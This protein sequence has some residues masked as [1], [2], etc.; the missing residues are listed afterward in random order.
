MLAPPP[1]QPAAAVVEE[2]AASRGGVSRQR[3]GLAPE[4]RA[5]A[6]VEACLRRRPRPR[7]QPRPFE[8]RL[9]IGHPAGDVTA[10]P[11]PRL[12]GASVPQRQEA[13]EVQVQVGGASTRRGRV[14]TALGAGKP[15]L[16][17]KKE[18]G[19]ITTRKSPVD[20]E[21]ELLFRKRER[22]YRK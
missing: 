9:V 4:T 18:A 8:A 1:T 14:L 17:G 21:Y 13:V 7:L 6:I 20:R 16:Q 5:Q 22:L 3:D 12:L 15:H 11:R 10:H 2:P 19:T